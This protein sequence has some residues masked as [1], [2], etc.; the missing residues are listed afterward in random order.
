MES[1]CWS[2][3]EPT[4]SARIYT[5]SSGTEDASEQDT[6]LFFDAQGDGRDSEVLMDNFSRPLSER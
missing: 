3:S 6:S 2:V 5:E 1:I 4:S